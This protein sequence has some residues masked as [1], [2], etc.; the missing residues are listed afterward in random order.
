MLVAE[1][2]ENIALCKVEKVDYRAD[3]HFAEKNIFK[4]LCVE[5]DAECSIELDRNYVG[6]FEMW[7]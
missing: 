3:L 5:P 2:M 6:R 4:E 1:A 7:T